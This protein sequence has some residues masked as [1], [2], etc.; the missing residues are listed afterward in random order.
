MATASMPGG[1]RGGGKRSAR[2]NQTVPPR[3]TGGSPRMKPGV[4]GR[5]HDPAS[6]ADLR[7]RSL[8]SG[9]TALER[10][11][12]TREKGRGGA[13][14]F[15]DGNGIVRAKWVPKTGK[16]PAHWSKFEPSGEQSHYLNNAGRPVYSNDRSHRIPSNGGGPKGGTGPGSPGPP[17]P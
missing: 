11:G 4:G 13:H 15:R 9:T 14:V 3:L 12:L 17:T 5:F 8:N 7:G 6:R 2:P 10:A 16:E 1:T